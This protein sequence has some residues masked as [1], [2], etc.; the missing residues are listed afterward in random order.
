MLLQVDIPYE[1][2]GYDSTGG[3]KVEEHFKPVEVPLSIPWLDE[4]RAEPPN[5][6]VRFRILVITSLSPS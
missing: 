2:S 6:P 1:S 5:P 4:D 3:A